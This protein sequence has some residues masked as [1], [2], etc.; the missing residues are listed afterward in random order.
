MRDAVVGEPPRCPPCRRLAA[1]SARPRQHI[2][3][4]GGT[5]CTHR[6]MGLRRRTRRPNHDLPLYARTATW[7]QR[8][9]V[10]QPW[11]RRLGRHHQLAG[12]ADLEHRDRA[13]GIDDDATVDEN[14]RRRAMAAQNPGPE[15]RDPP[16]DESMPPPSIGDAA[17]SRRRR[18]AGRPGR[19]LPSSARSA[20]DRRRPA[21]PGAAVGRAVRRALITVSSLRRTLPYG[22]MSRYRM[23]RHWRLSLADNRSSDSVV[24]ARWRCGG[25]RRSS[26]ALRCVRPRRG[27]EY[28][29]T[30]PSA[31]AAR[32]PRRSGAAAVGS[33]AIA[34]VTLTVV[35]ALGL[36]SGSS[37]STAATG[38]SPTPAPASGPPSSGPASALPSAPP[39]SLPPSGPSAL[40]LAAWQHSGVLMVGLRHRQHL[41]VR[42]RA[43]AARGS[44]PSPL[45]SSS[46]RRRRNGWVLHATLVAAQLGPAIGIAAAPA[47][48]PTGRLLSGELAI[49]SVS[50][51]ATSSV[52]FPSS[53]GQVDDTGF[54]GYAGL[55]GG[56]GLGTNDLVASNRGADYLIWNRV[57]HPISDPVHVFAAYKWT[58]VVAVALPDDVLAALPVGA[59]ISPTALTPTPPKPLHLASPATL[60]VG[61]DRRPSGQAYL[62]QPTDVARGRRVALPAASAMLIKAVGG[63]PD[64]LSDHRLG[65]LLSD[66]RRESRADQPRLTVRLRSRSSRQACSA[67]CTPGRR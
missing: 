26:I 33:I 46:V 25:T 44:T 30:D 17:R 57:R 53:A 66:P 16:G 52:V 8:R 24:S 2:H 48:P 37:V 35:A 47:L 18:R 21:R 27:H 38:A 40:P 50:G 12:V 22:S 65:R 11:Q 7:R 49:C 23:A 43:A 9:P 45:I 56:D 41:R 3:T 6:E 29:P 60:C 58:G 31:A 59:T 67:C 42:L 32:P 13:V 63:G 4:I 51:E 64:G 20:A 55:S 10:I 34:V 62:D 54:V 28:P 14:R 1:R 15:G 36:L 19:A 5:A 61:V 39:S